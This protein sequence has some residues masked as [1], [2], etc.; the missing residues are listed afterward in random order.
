MDEESHVR[1]VRD[2]PP[3]ASR[4][5]NAERASQACILRAA[6]EVPRGVEERVTGLMQR[7]LG[8]MNMEWSGDERARSGTFDLG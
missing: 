5:E 7:V 6:A 2:D 4:K 8:R 1:S 3:Q